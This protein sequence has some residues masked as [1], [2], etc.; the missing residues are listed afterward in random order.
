MGRDF[1][2]LGDVRLH[3]ISIHAPAW[4]ATSFSPQGGGAQGISIHAPAWGAT[5]LI[6]LLHQQRRISIHAPA[7]GATFIA[8][9]RLYPSRFQSTRPR[10]ARL[11]FNPYIDEISRFQSTR[12]RGARLRQVHLIALINKFQSTR[13]RGARRLFVCLHFASMGISIHAPAWGATSLL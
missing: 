12:P 6:D 11:L 10:G 2:A 1:R 4:G 3:R 9:S 7:W 5:P 8:I 13:P